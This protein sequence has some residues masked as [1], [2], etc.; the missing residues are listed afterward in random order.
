MAGSDPTTVTEIPLIDVDT[1]VH[2]IESQQDLLRDVLDTLRAANRARTI[3]RLRVT[4]TTTDTYVAHT[5]TFVETIVIA[6]TTLVAGVTVDILV[7]TI[8]HQFRLG[9]VSPV[10]IPFPIVI[11]RGVDLRVTFGAA[12]D[13]GDVYVIGTVE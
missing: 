6:G 10:I 1:L 7:G 9:G 4:D 12:Q 13:P 11:D 8:D 2:K 3:I 5:R